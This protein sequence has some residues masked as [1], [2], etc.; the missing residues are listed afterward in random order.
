MYFKIEFGFGKEPMS[1][2]TADYLAGAKE[3]SRTDE[4]LAL[5]KRKTHNERFA[6][7]RV[8]INDLFTRHIEEYNA[9]ERIGKVFVLS[10]EDNETRLSRVDRTGV[11]TV[12]FNP[13]KYTARF[14][15]TSFVELDHTVEIRMNG[16]NPYF[17]ESEGRKERTPTD[18]RIFNLLVDK[19]IR[20]LR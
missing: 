15:S 10:I 4:V 14:K 9:D 13:L 5:E 12:M 8:E 7:M 1:K 6:A 19:A 11:V 16:Q 3:R 18:D 2:N 20:A 17:C